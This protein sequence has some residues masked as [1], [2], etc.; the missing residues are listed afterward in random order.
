MCLQVSQLVKATK[1]SGMSWHKVCC[2]RHLQLLSLHFLECLRVCW[3]VTFAF[4]CPH[5]CRGSYDS[6]KGSG[7]CISLQ[8]LQWISGTKLKVVILW[9]LPKRSHIACANR[10]ED[11]DW[12]LRLRIKTVKRL[13]NTREYITKQVQINIRPIV[14]VK[15][16]G[17]S[18]TVLSV[19]EECKFFKASWDSGEKPGFLILAPYFINFILCI[20]NSSDQWGIILSKAIFGFLTF[21]HSKANKYKL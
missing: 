10:S 19:C 18:G 20:L 5:N 3:G 8:V 7:K 14:P 9:S 12:R 15:A 4:P 13:G 16:K 1:S 11:L 6:C 17:H 21:L 2:H